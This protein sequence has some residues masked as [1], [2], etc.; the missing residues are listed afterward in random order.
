MV[1]SLLTAGSLKCKWADTKINCKLREPSDSV[2][3]SQFEKSQTEKSQTG[4]SQTGTSQASKE[5][6][7]VKIHIKCGI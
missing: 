2:T 7:F 4:K 6:N 5:S 3:E 1:A